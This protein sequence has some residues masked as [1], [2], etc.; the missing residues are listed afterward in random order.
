[1]IESQIKAQYAP[2][3]CEELSVQPEGV[4]AVS[5]GKFSGFGEEE[6]M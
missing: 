5:P 1:M 6:E 3:R 4:I 2:P